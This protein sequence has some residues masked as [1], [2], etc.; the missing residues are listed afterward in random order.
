MEH[1][2]ISQLLNDSTV[3]K[4]VTKKWIEVNYLSSGQ[5]FASRNIRFKI[6]MLKSDL[7]DYSNAYIAVKGR[8]SVRATENTDIGQKYIAFKKMLHLDHGQ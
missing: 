7:Y 1:Y 2:K 4:F 5:Y 3:L 8:L 6:S